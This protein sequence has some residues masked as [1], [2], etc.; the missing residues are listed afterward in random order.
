MRSR[1]L[2]LTVAGIILLT[3]VSI[4]AGFYLDL[5]WFT[6]LQ[7]E[8][9]FWTRIKAQWGLRLAAWLLMFAFM[10]VNLLI[11][12]RQILSFPNLA[13]RE[14]LMAGGY[15]RL[16]AP[17]RITLL[18]LVVSAVISWLFSGFAAAYWMDLLKFLNP[19]PFNISDPLFGLDISFYVFR[20]PFYRFIYTYLMTA[21]ILPL[22]MV[23]II[24]LLLNPPKQ[25]GARLRLP[26]GPGLTHVSIILAAIFSLKAW[27]YH[28]QRLELVFSER[29]V[30][31]GAGYTDIFAHQRVL[32]LLLVLAVAMA[33]L[34]IVN[35]FLS[36]PRLLL[37]G[38]S[39]LLAVS[40]LG[41][42]AYPAIIQGFVVEPQEFALE[43]EYLQHNINFTRQAY[44]LDRFRTRDY[45]ARE[46]LT[47]SDLEQN[48]GTI[49]N[50]RLWDYRPLRDTLNE[51]QA[52]RPYYRFKDV[53]VDRYIVDGQYRQVMLAARELDK[54]RLPL[55]AQTWVN[56]HLQYTHGYGLAMSPVNEVSPEGLPRYFIR[57]IPAA[58]T[59]G[60]ELEQPSIYF[61]EL[62]D[63]YVIVN[64]ATPE[65]HFAVTGDQ[66]EFT[67]YTGEAGIP[68]G[69][70]L[71][72]AL[73]ALRFGEY[74]ILISGELTAESRVL[75]NRNIHDRVR[76]IAPFLRYDQD[77]YLVVNDGRLFWIQDAY[78]VT[79]HYPYS[80]PYG[81]FNYIRNSVKVITDAYH[82]SVSFYITDPDDPLA[83]AYSRIF[84]GLFKTFAEM[85]AGLARHLRYPEDLFNIQARVLT[86]YHVTD[87]NVFYT[88]EDLWAIPEEQD[89]GEILPMEP[90]YTILQ[91]PG[92]AEPEF[93]LILPFTPNKR[94][95]MIAWMVARC[96]QP[97]YGQVELFLF[98]IERV[99]MGPRQVENRIDQD[100]EI[101]AQFTL[102]SQAGSRVIRGNLLVLPINDSLLYVEPVFLRAEGGGLPEL[103]RVIVVFQ[104]TVVMEETLEQALVRIFDARE[105]PPPGDPAEDPPNLPSLPAGELS[106]LIAEAQA[107]Y[108]EAIERQREGDWAGY[109]VKIKEL[110]QIL[111][112]LARLTE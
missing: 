73:F 110:E 108:S 51:L 104:E 107:A 28:L 72:R 52:I 39:A 47:W 99:V 69:S 57:D 112:E 36:R 103:S 74:R 71:R 1:L 82:G 94:N 26:T 67:S 59:G 88:G 76:K 43:R 75:F 58:T 101:S 8:S 10:L 16:L 46:T 53:D 60:L 102:W 79:D 68:L 37:Y 86:R 41:G 109:G 64:T 40:V 23:G 55:P 17:R 30:A 24:Y 42:W 62:T 93:V 6:E 4:G 89:E 78:T 18:F 56:M 98:P 38:I 87:P 100:T 66:N 81:D 45:P 12:R 19:A 22:I 84:P 2:W 9:V 83:A 21:L 65:F 44:G 111:N 11:T 33:L 106:A 50:V 95:N 27:D 32:Q 63:D 90:Y 20:L 61:G 29:G 5:L 105:D 14:R 48:P 91:L 34:F 7:A 85:P 49:N 92:Y 77:P 25:P 80:T 97:N 35:I 3:G 15:M 13:L 70:F 96:D 54:S 31:F